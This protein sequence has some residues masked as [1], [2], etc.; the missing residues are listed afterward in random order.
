MHWGV[1]MCLGES[2]GGETTEGLS[3]TVIKVSYF[4]IA[5]IGEGEGT[6]CPWEW[7]GPGCWQY[8][9]DWEKNETKT[10]KKNLV[11]GGMMGIWWGES[12]RST[13]TAHSLVFKVIIMLWVTYTL[14]KGS[15]SCMLIPCREKWPVWI[16]YQKTVPV[17]PQW[18]KITYW[19]C[20]HCKLVTCR[21]IASLSTNHSILPLSTL[22][23][24]S[25]VC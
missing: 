8:S 10:K 2:R 9:G 22:R 20:L 3:H 25:M 17:E 18:G 4:Y 14:D 11:N 15:S 23:K 13:L 1:K 24:P 5:L 6:S 12:F 21:S 16:R 19:C 7:M